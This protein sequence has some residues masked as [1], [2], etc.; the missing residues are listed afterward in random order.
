MALKAIGIKK[1][2]E[3][4]IP[5]F[6]YIATA[7]AVRLA[8]AKLVL[9]DINQDNYTIDYKKVKEKITKKLKQL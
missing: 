4:I 7:N 8:G 9:A 6:T 5:C 2:D 3:V 1:E